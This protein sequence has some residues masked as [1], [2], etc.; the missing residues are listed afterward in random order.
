MEIKTNSLKLN[1][2]F[3]LVGWFE[4]TSWRKLIGE[5]QRGRKIIPFKMKLSLSL[6]GTI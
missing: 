2:L 6:L 5:Y 1:I 3:M 4:T